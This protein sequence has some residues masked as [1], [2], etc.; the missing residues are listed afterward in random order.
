MQR[1]SWSPH[2]DQR[3]I[4][5]NTRKNSSPKMTTYSQRAL[6][7]PEIK[8]VKKT[9]IGKRLLN[10]T[11]RIFNRKTLIAVLIMG[12]LLFELRKRGF[13]GN[14]K[15]LS[16]GQLENVRKEVEKTVTTTLSKNVEKNSKNE[17]QIK[18]DA[19]KNP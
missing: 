17:K 16:P 12:A 18:N 8:Q 14:S 2:N 13:L 3:R 7:P 5:T 9:P 11:K 1:I 15:P 4:K 19:K 10:L 6:S